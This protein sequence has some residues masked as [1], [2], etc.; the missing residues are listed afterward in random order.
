MVQQIV[1]REPCGQSDR[2]GSGIGDCGGW[3]GVHHALHIGN[4][5]AD[6]DAAATCL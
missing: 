4:D 2:R 5:R 1:A 3:H 6:R